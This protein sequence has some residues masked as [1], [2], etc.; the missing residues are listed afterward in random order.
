MLI[1]LLIILLV[2]GLVL[3]VV[4]LLP[5]DSTITR[6]IQVVVLVSVII[7]LLKTFLV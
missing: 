5:L 6:I 7:Y 4:Q 1:D 3:Y 2:V